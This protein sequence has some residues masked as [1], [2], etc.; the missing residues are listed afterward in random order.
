ML[1]DS[2]RVWIAWT[3]KAVFDVEGPLVKVLSIGTDI[4]EGRRAEKAL[5]RLSTFDSLT[6][7]SNSRAFDISLN[8]EWKHAQRGGY[9]ISMM[10]IDVDQYTRTSG[11]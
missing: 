5:Q 7:I 11:H 6:G 2:H 3:N 1:R 8:E 9:K 10:M 4:T